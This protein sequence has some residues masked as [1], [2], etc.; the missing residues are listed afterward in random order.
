[1]NAKEPI[2]VGV[3]GLGFMGQTH[4]KAYAAANEAG[5]TNALAAV[6]DRDEGRLSGRIESAGNIDTG[7]DDERLFDPASLQAYTEPS[8]LLADASVELVSI[9]T[10]TETHADLAIAALEAGKHVLIE[11][12]V[13]VTSEQVQ[14]VADAARASDRV[15]MPAMCIRYWPEWAWIKTKIEDG[16]LGKV[17]SATFHR[18]GSAPAWGGG[19]YADLE[20]CGGALVDLHI[21]DA[22]FVRWC[23]GEPEQVCST[24]SLEHVTTL[25]KFASG[26][27]HVVAE[28]GWGHDP[29]F[30]FLMR[31]LVVF[32]Q[33]TIS[34]NSSKDD[35]F[36]IHREGA[37][38]PII[39]DPITGYDGQIRHLI[40]ALGAGEKP[41]T[42]IDDA[43]GVARLL[44]AE[45][46]SLETGGPVSLAQ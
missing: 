30:G 35:P 6:C 3:I 26:P 43:I 41:Q 17:R 12:P 27:Q 28:G 46:R 5:F 4:I 8:A 22:D 19:F 20:R 10:H 37:T 42:T 40:A 45:R 11:K 21:H 16:S 38:T 2:N 39:V 7:T 29:A 36:M 9:C 24:G 25:Y 31:Y 34:Y 32:E 1:M 33:A 44:E 23:F 13:A 18:L 14:R 15:C